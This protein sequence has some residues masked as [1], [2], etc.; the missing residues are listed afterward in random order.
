MNQPLVMTEDQGDRLV[1]TNCNTSRR[2]ALSPE[3]YQGLK[4]A[5]MEAA[6]QPRIKAVIL[7]AKGPF[8]CSGGDLNLLAERQHL[9]LADRASR[10]EALHDLIRLIRTCPKPVIAAVEGGA[11]GAG[12]SIALA[13][14]FIVAAVGAKFRAAY[15]KAGLVPDGGLTSALTQLLPRAL[16]SEICLTG[17][18]ISAERFYNLGAINMLCPASQT[19]SVAQGIATGLAKGPTVTQG[20]IKALLA[21]AQSTD[22]DTQ[23]D[24]ERD[25]MA[26]AIGAAEAVEGIAAFLEKRAPN[27]QNSQGK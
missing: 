11:A 9:S 15:V 26:E 12:L 16:V 5:L 25:T 17:R 22:A 24:I 1:V 27:F 20:K 6:T 19:L 21:S 8:F 3:Y 23:L 13:C 4:S 7:T 2:N 10:I 18:S 14:D